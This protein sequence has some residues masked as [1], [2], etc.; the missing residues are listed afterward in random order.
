MVIKP[1]CDSESHPKPT[2]MQP[3]SSYM[4]VNDLPF[5]LFE[6]PFQGHTL[7]CQDRDQQPLT[8]LKK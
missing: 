8:D 6:L 7:K 1:L 3:V 5:H 2:N 4:C